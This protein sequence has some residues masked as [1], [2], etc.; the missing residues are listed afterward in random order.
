M[1][2]VKHALFSCVKVTVLEPSIHSD[3]FPTLSHAYWYLCTWLRL[4]NV[5]KSFSFF[6]VFSI[7]APVIVLHPVHVLSDN[8]M[9]W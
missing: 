7:D 5:P 3:L 9:E 2:Q 6:L 4:I 8:L 1:S